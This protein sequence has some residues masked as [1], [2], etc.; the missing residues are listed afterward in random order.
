MVNITFLCTSVNTT[1]YYNDN[2]ALLSFTTMNTTNTNNC[3]TYIAPI[4]TKSFK[5][6]S[7]T[8]KII[9]LFMHGD[10][11]KMY[12]GNSISKKYISVFIRKMSRF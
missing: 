11:Q 10:M 4:P 9:W 5:L 2:Y 3:K 6:R 1:F 7:V 8:S 12:G